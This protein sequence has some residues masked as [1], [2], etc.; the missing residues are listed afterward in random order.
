[1]EFPGSWSYIDP[2]QQHDLVARWHLN[3]DNRPRLCCIVTM[4]ST[5]DQQQLMYGGRWTVDGGA[6]WLL[7]VR[8]E[9]VTHGAWMFVQLESYCRRVV[10]YN[11]LE[12]VKGI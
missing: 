6:S 3:L 2:G 12:G 7:A 4:N 5:G 1:M 9:N 8:I 11:K 10:Y